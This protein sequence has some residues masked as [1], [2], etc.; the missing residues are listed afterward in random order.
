MTAEVNNEGKGAFSI[1]VTGVAST[2]NGGQG[3][4]ANPEGVSLL[5]LRTQLYV[6]TPSTGAGNLGAGIVADATTKGTDI[7]N[8]LA[9]GGSIAGKVY[10]GNTIQVT[11][12]T[13]ITAPVVW[14]SDKYL[15]LTGSAD[16]SGL[17]ATLYVEYLR[18]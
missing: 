1:H 5:I 9:M 13:E 16:L 4:I 6:K 8:D 18:V 3:A 12:K 11:A 7:L 10:N 2:A 17:D 14:T 15:T